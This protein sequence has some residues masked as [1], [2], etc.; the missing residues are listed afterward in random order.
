MSWCPKKRFLVSPFLGLLAVLGQAAQA[1]DFSKM[2]QGHSFWSATHLIEVKYDADHT[3]W[4]S[5]A[6]VGGF[7]NSQGS[8]VSFR[9][10]YDNKGLR[11]T[12]LA[13]MTQVSSSLG[14][15]WGVG[16]GE[17]AAKY[18]ITPSLKL[19]AIYQTQL[20][21][22]SLFYVKGST[23][24]GGQLREK[25]CI[26]N[27]DLEGEQEVNCRLAASFLPPAETLKYLYR[28]RP[29]NHSQVQ[30]QFSAQF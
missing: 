18:V 4:L 3:N 22:N 30:L 26:G 11:N 12:S 14:F 1:A 29:N 2:G 16:T 9:P 5:Q 23:V 24:L 8:W 21:K 6:R 28:E 19:G 20:S 27:Y 7:E 10:L 15:I 17:R 25:T 13:W